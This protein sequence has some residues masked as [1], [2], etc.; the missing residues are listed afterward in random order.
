MRRARPVT[1]IAFALLFW[2]PNA[3]A[4]REH[5]GDCGYYTNRDGQSVPRPCGNAQSDAPPEGSTAV[6]RDGRYSYSRHHTGT[7]SGHSGVQRWLR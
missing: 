6:C 3:S 1:L 7:C 2:I 5:P 4:Q